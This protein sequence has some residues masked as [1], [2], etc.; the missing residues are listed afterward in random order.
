MGEAVD[1][2]VGVPGI[3]DGREVK[4]EPVVDRAVP[5]PQLARRA[6]HEIGTDEHGR[7]WG[8]RWV[9]T[10]IDLEIVVHPINTLDADDMMLLQL[11]HAWRGG[12]M[13][14][15]PLPCAGGMLDQPACVMAALGVMSMTEA[16]LKPKG[17]T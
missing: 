13:G 2:L 17:K 16:K 7:E 12:E 15:G 14:A 6:G 10:E 1:V 11:W 8:D 3:P 5:D 9:F 4:R